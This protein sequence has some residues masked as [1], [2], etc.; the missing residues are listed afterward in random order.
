MRKLNSITI[1]TVA[2]VPAKLQRPF[3][4]GRHL[5]TRAMNIELQLPVKNT[6]GAPYTLTA[7]DALDI[8]TK[9]CGSF[10]LRIGG[11]RVEAVD[12]TITFPDL[13]N[14]GI[15]L[16]GR[17]QK[18]AGGDLAAYSATAPNAVTIVA[19]ATS[20]VRLTLVRYFYPERLG[21]EGKEFCPFNSQLAD[22]LLTITRGGAFATAQLT[23]DGNCAGVVNLDDF[24][25]ESESGW[26]PI[27][28]ISKNNVAGLNHD[29]PADCGALFAM[30]EESAAGSATALTTVSLTREG[31]YPI[32]DQVEAGD[33]VRESSERVPLGA[34][35][36]NTTGGAAGVGAT[37]LYQ[38]PDMVGLE[39]L[40]V[41]AGWKFRQ[42]NLNVAQPSTRWLYSP[43]MSDV[44]RD[45][46]VVPQFQGQDRPPVA[47]LS[48]TIAGG[49]PSVPGHIAAVLSVAAVPPD[50]P[51]AALNDVYVVT[52][53]AATLVPS[54]VLDAAAKSL[55]PQGR[56]ALASERAK[57]IMGGRIPNRAN[58]R[59][60]VGAAVLKARSSAE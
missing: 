12:E 8:M 44:Y 43:A 35:D 55:D 37:V 25:A 46:I 42:A 30:W 29:G 41:G 21:K 26:A 49:R 54:P 14:I 23:Q 56:K 45:T 22:M 52:A 28:R 17:D 58:S 50:S 40:R 6:G 4:T 15:A 51:K 18:F 34:Y 53:R 1:G 39:D 48:A 24:D 36:L 5:R 11:K 31:D 60:T 2:S 13:R 16:A 59:A 57:A 3:D 33:L 9:V 27:A 47:L 32:H 10:D 20:T 19:G 7:A 38:L